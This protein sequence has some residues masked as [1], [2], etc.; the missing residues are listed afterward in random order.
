MIQTTRTRTEDDAIVYIDSE[1]A[2]EIHEGTIIRPFGETDKIGVVS[3]THHS[4]G[5][6]I[7][8]GWHDEEYRMSSSNRVQVLG[9]FNL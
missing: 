7:F 3:V 6:T 2:G 5:E 9:Y 8:R 4:Y 1:L